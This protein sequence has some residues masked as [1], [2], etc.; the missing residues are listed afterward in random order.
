M[1]HFEFKAFAVHNEVDLNKIAVSCGIPKKYTWEEPLI[2]DHHLLANI[3][4]GEFEADG[5][6]LVFSFGCI[7]LV[8]VPEDIM[9]RLLNFIKG[10]EPETDLHNWNKYTDEYELRIEPESTLEITDEYAVVPNFE[11]FHIELVAIVIAKSVAL[12]KTEEELGKIFD[13]LESIIDRLEHGQLRVGNRELAR[14]TAQ[15][16]R[17]QYNTISYIMILDKPDITWS[18]SDASLFYDKMSDIFELNDRYTILTKKADIM[19][20]IINGFSSISHSIRGLFVE[21]VI[22][23]LIVFEVIL[24]VLDLVL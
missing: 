23:L 24:M 11:L 7:V 14:T 9:P 3:L 4:G 10:F 13:Q 22:V 12:E 1:K 19:N 21:W 20:N 15:V 17:H 16:T 8:N 18:N 5:K 2:L 6:V